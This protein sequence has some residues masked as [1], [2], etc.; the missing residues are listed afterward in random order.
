M[1]VSTAY[2]K[3]LMPYEASEFCPLNGQFAPIMSST[4]IG[5]RSSPSTS[6]HEHTIFVNSA[7]EKTG[8][9]KALLAPAILARE[10]YFVVV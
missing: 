7:P 5:S 8:K 1:L 4:A 3:R 2:C 10:G 6:E 9:L